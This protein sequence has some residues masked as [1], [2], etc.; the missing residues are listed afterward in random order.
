MSSESFTFKDVVVVGA[1]CGVTTLNVFLSGALTV[2]LPTIGRDL[3]FKQADLQ[4]PL[5]VFAL[6]YGCLLLFFGRVGDI[7]GARTLFLVGSA[8]FSVWSI[9]TAFAPNAATFILFVALK[10]MGAA[11]NTPAGIGLLSIYFPPGPK[12][13]TAFGAVGAG[14]PLGFI[15]GLVVGGVLTDSHAT[16]RAIFYIQAAL[17]GLFVVLGW[18]ALPRAL[19]TQRYKKGLDWGGAVI[20][21]VA[22]GLMTYSLADS[23]TATRGW[24]TPH[25]PAL[26]ATS[27]VLLSVLF[28]YEKWREQRDMSVLIPLSI[29]RQPNAKMGSM[30]VVAF[31]AWWSFNTL[32]YFATLYYQQVKF[33]DPAHTSIRFIPMVISGFI[34]N[35]V[36]GFLVSRLPGQGLILTGLAATMLATIIFS[37][38]NVNASYWA[39]AFLVM[40]FVVGVDAVYPVGNL[41]LV[42]RFDEAS[43]SLAG[44]IFAVATR[45]GTS[46]GLALTSTIA[47]A[48]SDRYNAARPDLHADSP[49][50]LMVGFRAAGWT[51]FAAAGVAFC[52]AA[53]GLRNIGVVGKTTL[54]ED[55]DVLVPIPTPEGGKP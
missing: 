48:A 38:I 53:F 50:V 13:S 37:T 19:E 10:G 27:V 17:G 55:E 49:E 35:I 6:S 47:T 12:R 8:W 29:W 1:L 52:I 22:V 11:A 24:A 26:L 9:A 31:L 33:V 39:S 20:S 4:W 3:D 42:R 44:G 21:T 16:W 30:V 45:L 40:V 36:T 18:L 46:I 32:A 41:H 34:V 14:Q 43:Q 5:N 51:C 54:Q 2:A 28:Y 25:I 23:G 7:V 15:G